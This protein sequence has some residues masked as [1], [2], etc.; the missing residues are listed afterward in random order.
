MISLWPEEREISLLFLDPVNLFSENCWTC[1]PCPFGR[2]NRH[3]FYTV[4]CRVRKRPS[5]YTP[6]RYMKLSNRAVNMIVRP[7]R[8][9]WRV[10]LQEESEMGKKVVS[11]GQHGRNS[12]K[13]FVGSTFTRQGWQLGEQRVAMRESK[14]N[15]VHSTGAPMYVFILLYMGKESLIVSLN[16][17][18]HVSKSQNPNGL[19]GNDMSLRR[20]MKTWGFSWLLEIRIRENDPEL[21][22]RVDGSIL[23]SHTTVLHWKL[24]KISVSFSSFTKFKARKCKGGNTKGEGNG[25]Y[26][27]TRS[28]TDQKHTTCVDMNVGGRRPAQTITKNLVQTLCE[29]FG[30]GDDDHRNFHNH[31]FYFINLFRSTDV[32][33]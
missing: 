7:M 30:S 33:L 32:T 21:L 17:I 14:G 28:V 15:N 27:L 6:H 19:M 25:V 29:V 22:L 13:M 3:R 8:I 26:V 9:K 2:G 31:R 23:R 10:S 4:Q 5:S 18:R 20:V 24:N 11:R 1:S 12:S 16:L